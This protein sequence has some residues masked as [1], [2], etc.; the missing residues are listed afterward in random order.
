[1]SGLATDGHQHSIVVCSTI[2]CIRC[3]DETFATQTLG[4][5]FDYVAPPILF[6]RT[7]ATWL[8]ATSASTP[9][10]SASLTPLA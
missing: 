6:T 2:R 4:A 1:M 9:I 5:P 8:N 10:P 3:S 7:R